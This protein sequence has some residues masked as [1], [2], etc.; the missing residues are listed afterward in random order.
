MDI[1]LTEHRATPTEQA[2]V[3]RVLDPLNSSSGQP[4]GHALVRKT[5]P[6]DLLLPVLHAIQSRIGWI[7]PGAVNY[8]AMR[9]DLPPAEIYGVASF[10]AMFSLELRAPVVAHV[11]DD[12]ACLA[13][14]AGRLC[15]ELE[16][17]LGPARQPAS[18]NGA[19][20][21]RTPCL[22]L[23]ER[24][25]AALI[26]ASG[27]PPG[28]ASWPRLPS[29]VFGKRC[30]RQ[31]KACFRQSRTTL[32]PPSPLPGQARQRLRSCAASDA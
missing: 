21:Q 18:V 32:M 20:W 23:C 26:T 3:D 27:E 10:Y 2:A 28:S 9:M 11:C 31:S 24:A 15:A 22:G 14:G 25:P 4:N 7:S 6:R 16:N 5:P 17:A 12:I 19:A 30:T 1:H 29:A 8:V 13:R